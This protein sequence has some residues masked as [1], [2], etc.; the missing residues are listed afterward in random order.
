MD[1]TILHVDM[2]AFFT[3]VEQRDR[4]EL[5]GRP[6]VVGSPPDQRGVVAAASYEARQFGVHSAMPSREAYRRCPQAVFL[7][8]DMNRY[9]TVSRQIRAIFDRFTPLVEPLSIDEAFLDVSGVRHL[10]GCGREV[11]QRIKDAIRDDVGLT[12]S[13]GVATNKFLAKLAS[14]MDKPGGLTEVPSTP[15]EIVAFL[16]PLPVGRIW[17]VGKVTGAHLARAGIQTIGQLQKVEFRELTRILGRT[18]ADHLRRLAHGEDDREIETERE[19]KSI[20]NEHTFTQDCR[21]PAVV[22]ATLN[23]LVDKV[24]RRLRAAGK[25]AGLARIKLRWQGFDTITRQRGVDPV[26][27]D[28][29]TLRTVANELFDG[30]ALIK[31]VRLIGFGVSN[32]T[33]EVSHQLSLFGSDDRNRDRNER[34]SH[35]VDDIRRDFGDASIH[36]ASRRET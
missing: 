7:R 27:C 15:A 11:A 25:L 10:F 13:A 35:V 24:G 18:A 23:D 32:L 5:R 20:S 26:A 16:A 17:G 9:V 14:D 1:R 4:P 6:V 12:A 8:G 22:R 31:P 33:T 29:F 19:E 2:D 30:E 28:D 3:S 36:R 21:D 34:L